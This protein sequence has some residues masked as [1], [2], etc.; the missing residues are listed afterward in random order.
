MIRLIR[1]KDKFFQY[2]IGFIGKK[3]ILSFYVGILEDDPAIFKFLDW[4]ITL[5]KQDSRIYFVI[6]N[7]TVGLAWLINE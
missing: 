6:F 4:T 3:I 2:S 1:V 5:R 7:F